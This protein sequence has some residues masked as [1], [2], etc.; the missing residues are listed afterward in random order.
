MRSVLFVVVGVALAADAAAQSPDGPMTLTLDAA[1]RIAEARNPGVVVA[2]QAAAA[3]EAD[4]AGASRRP[5]PSLSLESEGLLSRRSTPFADGQQIQ[6]ALQ[7][8][9]ETG[10][11]RGLRTEQARL[12]LDSSRASAQDALRQLRFDVRLAYLRV[13]LAKADEE[14]TRE[15]LAEI[16]RVLAINRARYDAGEL[17]GVELRRLQVERFRFAD[18]AFASELALK[19]AR[20]ELLALLDLHPLDRPFDVADELASPAEAPLPSAQADAAAG[21]SLDRALTAR[22]DLQ[23]ARH[24]V[25]RAEAGIRLQ[26]ALG[27]PTLVVGAGVQRDYGSNGLVFSVGMPLPIFNRNEAGVRR[28]TAERRQAEAAQRATEARVALEVRQ[29]LDAADVARRRLAYIEGEYLRSA[30]EARDIVLASYRSGAASLID[31][32]DAER[33]LREALRTR[34]RARFDHRV[35]VFQYEAAVGAPAPGPERNRP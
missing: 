8:E 16:D 19:R 31:Y 7:Q 9:L 34:N 30:R 28:G 14:V 23:A 27:R 32:L 18:E 15:T 10:G 12:A 1:L 25:E 4:L 22:P 26:R 20:S 35:S 6:L 5:N 24:D 29:A 17:A 3:A 13:V 21:A 11:R 2:Q 33:A